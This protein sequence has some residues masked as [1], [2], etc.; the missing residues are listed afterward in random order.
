MFG[1]REY[2]RG[3]YWLD[4]PGFGESED[5]PEYPEHEGTGPGVQWDTVGQHHH[6]EHPRKGH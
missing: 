3:M 4:M 1:W 2:V 5:L 6:T